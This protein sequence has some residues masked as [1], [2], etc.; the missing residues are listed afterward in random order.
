MGDIGDNTAHTLIAFFFSITIIATDA[1]AFYFTQNMS[2]AQ[3]LM[4]G[5]WNIGLGFA[6]SWF[7]GKLTVTKEGITEETQPPKV[8]T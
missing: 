3:L 4:V 5:I 2:S 7:I 6:N 1:V 8:T